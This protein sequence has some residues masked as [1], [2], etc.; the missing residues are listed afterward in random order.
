MKSNIQEQLRARKLKPSGNSWD[1]LDAKLEQDRTKHSKKRALIIY[2]AASVAA[3]ILVLV[4]VFNSNPSEQVTP[5][6]QTVEN[7]EQF[8]APKNDLIPENTTNKQE[9]IAMPV[10]KNDVE[11]HTPQIQ[12]EPKEATIKHSIAFN[13]QKSIEDID[14]SDDKVTL[15]IPIQTTKSADISLDLKE[16][17]DQELD[18]LLLDAQIAMDVKKQKLQRQSDADWLLVEVEMELDQN[19]KDKVFKAIKNAVKNPRNTITKR[20]N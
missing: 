4:S 6:I 5:V 12:T 13:E 1:V 7:E 3:I 20:D 2:A 14:I 16:V 8:E 17:S 11:K 10:E 15:E 9:L 18:A 19:F